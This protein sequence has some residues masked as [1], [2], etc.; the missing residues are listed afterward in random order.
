[1]LTTLLKE[2]FPE[3]ASDD[4]LIEQIADVATMATFKKDDIVIDYGDFIKSVPLVLTG[5][6][7][8]IRE[9][10]NEQEMLLYFLGSGESCAASFS[11]C[12]IR[13]RSE[14]RAISESESKVLMIP[15]E[16]ADRWMGEF[17]VWREFIISMYDTRMLS[18]I[19]TIDRVAFTKLDEKLLHYLDE[20]TRLKSST[21][22]S[23]SHHEIAQD[24]NASRESVSRL[25]KR[26]EV[27][28]KVKLGRN[29]ITVIPE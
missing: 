19:D 28:G 25:L 8:I 11:C 10:E 1:M 23:I 20:L 16:Y 3:L 6:L 22:L 18:L 9:G 7:K 2:R 14:I 21:H 5:L 27:N 17:S 29:E 13:K 15:L 26:L 4:K 24:L 12:L